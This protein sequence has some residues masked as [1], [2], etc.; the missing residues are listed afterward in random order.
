MEFHKEEF[1]ISDDRRRVD[2]DVVSGLL[3][4]GYWGHRRPRDVVEKLIPRSLCFSLF[5]N[6]TQI[7]F[8]RVVTD[9]TVFS[10]LSD[11]V[12]TEAYRG[13]GLGRWM[14]DCI[15]THP[16]IAITQFVLQTGSAFGL[17]EKFGFKTSG[18]LMTR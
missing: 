9:G 16:E 5:R 10:W 6:D 11:F 15:L 1:T 8:A 13:M 17:Y 7:G 18:K 14:L 4:G 3:A 12:I 2:I